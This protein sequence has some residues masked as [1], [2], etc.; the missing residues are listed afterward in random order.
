MP[1]LRP[2]DSFK[3]VNLY[4]Q[5]HQPKR[6]RRFQFSEIGSDIS[7]FDDKL[8]AAISQEGCR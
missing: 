1:T 6:L 2:P 5:V 8:N 7:Y 3:Y 4:F